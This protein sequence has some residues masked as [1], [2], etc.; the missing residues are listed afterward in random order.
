[1]KGEQDENCPPDR[2]DGSIEPAEPPIVPAGMPGHVPMVGVTGVGR[3]RQRPP[4][5]PRVVG[6]GNPRRRRRDGRGQDG[7]ARDACTRRSVMGTWTSCVRACACWPSGP[8]AG[9]TSRQRTTSVDSMSALRCAKTPLVP[10]AQG[11]KRCPRPPGW[12]GPASSGVDRP[13]SWYPR[14]NRWYGRPFRMVPLASGP[15]EPCRS[16]GPT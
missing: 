2:G 13:H 15:S 1:V 3:R 16:Q 5:H 4:R 6:L 9:G 7:G 8:Q 11:P 10:L 14:C 12:C